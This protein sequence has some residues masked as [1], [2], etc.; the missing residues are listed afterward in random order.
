MTS[1]HKRIAGATTGLVVASLL[2]V[3]LLAWLFPAVMESWNAQLVD[4]LFTIR[5]SSE[6]FHSPYDTSIFHVDISDQTL[7]N[8]KNEYLNRADYAAVARNLADMKVAAQIW[9]FIFPAR[10]ALAEDTLFID[11]ARLAGNIYF[12]TAFRLSQTDVP[13][14]SPDVV[15]GSLQYLR[16]TK[17]LV[18]VE[19]GAKDFYYGYDPL[20]NFLDLAKVSKGTGYLNLNPDHDGVFRRAPLLIH[21]DGAFFPSIDLRAACEYLNVPPENILVKAGSLVLHGAHKPGKEPHDI[22]IPIDR[23]GNMI[24]SYVGPWESLRH[25][26]FATIW[27]LTH[28]EDE[29]EMMGEEL[30]GGI[31]IVDQVT[32]G[33]ADVGPI[34]TDENCPL[35]G[36]HSNIMNTILQ[37][38]FLR[39]A[40]APAMLGVEVILMGI[41]LWLS[42]RFSSL[43]M[44]LGMIVLLGLYLMAVAGMFLYAH[45]ILNILRPSLMIGAT[46]VVIVAYRYF[47]EEKQKEVLRRSFEA[48]FPQSV[49]KK[50][51]A[52]PDMITSAGQKK[53]LTMMFTDIKGFTS[54][55]SKA[56]PDQIQQML[57]EYFDAMVEIVFRHGG[58]V[59]KFMGDGLMVFFGDPESQPD[60]ALRCVRAAID[61]QRKVR[62]I[63]ERWVSEGKMPLQIRI[64]INTG[65]VIVG[66]MGSA[67]RLSYTVLGSDVNLAQRLESNSPVN[68]VLISHATHEKVKDHIQARSRGPIQVKGLDEPVSVYEVIIDS[69]SPS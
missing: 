20:P 18:K 30:A 59:D 19:D 69:E 16:T 56:K 38:D 9:D 24:V 58:T 13:Q 48:Y 67:R 53:E 12:G 36:V 63:R 21:Y 54:Y 27:D 28:D 5:A 68:G 41:L 44:S 47:N 22:R 57:N 65:Q 35:S 6:K 55:S 17:W 26:D 31:V 52:N 33:S 32:T 43:A 10:L 1:T 62:E 66:N 23:H 8:L 39:E 51:M 60:H 50:I 4:R 46:L 7:R 34:P 40:S 25:Y 49:V 37:E 61:M 14:V 3:Y 11:A 42:L 45:L 64:G 15:P 29:K 2:L